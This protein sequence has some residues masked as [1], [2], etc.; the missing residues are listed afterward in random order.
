MLDEIYLNFVHNPGAYPTYYLSQLYIE[1]L[2]KS[3]F[4]FHDDITL[5]KE[6]HEAFLKYGSTGFDVI[7]KGFKKELKK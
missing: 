3:Y 1:D 6:F 5:D 7:E 4:Q 2:K